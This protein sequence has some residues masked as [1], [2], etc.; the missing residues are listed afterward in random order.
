M[1]FAVLGVENVPAL[2]AAI[3]KHYP[4]EHFPLNNGE[5]LIVDRGTAKEVCDKLGVTDGTNGSALVVAITGYFGRKNA[6]LWEWMKVKSV[7]VS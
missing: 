6:D 7:Q 2:G 5:W 1:I 3:G 4:A